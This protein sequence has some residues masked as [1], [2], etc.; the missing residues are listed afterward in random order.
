MIKI[1]SCF[2]T[3]TSYTNSFTPSVIN[4]LVCSKFLPQQIS[5]IAVSHAKHECE[6]NAVI[7]WLLT[8]VQ[9]QLPSNSRLKFSPFLRSG[10]WLGCD[11]LVIVWDFVNSDKFQLFS[12]HFFIYVFSCI[13]Y[14]Y[15]FN[16]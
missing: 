14:V 1:H 9:L 16:F 10:L 6:D 2:S 8:S 11:C 12:I 13:M 4:I 15:I 7:E 5:G 3:E